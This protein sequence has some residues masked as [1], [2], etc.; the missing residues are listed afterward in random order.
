LQ[1]HIPSDVGSAND[2][3]VRVQWYVMHS[4]YRY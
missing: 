3:T 1:W 4:L 2:G